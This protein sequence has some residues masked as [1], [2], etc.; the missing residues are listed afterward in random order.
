[1][2]LPWEMDVQTLASVAPQGATPWS[3]R[4]GLAAAAAAPAVAGSPGR[5]LR[6]IVDWLVAAH[7]ARQTA[8]VERAFRH[9]LAAID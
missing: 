2:S 9:G 7:R 1:M 8:A 4:A 5:R 6:I 3:A